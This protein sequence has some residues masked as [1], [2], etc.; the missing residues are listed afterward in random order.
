MDPSRR[1]LGDTAARVALLCALVL[2]FVL[3]F[4]LPPELVG[5]DHPLL[6]AVM[7]P[8]ALGVLAALLVR[9]IQRVMLHSDHGRPAF[10]IV[11]TLCLSLLVFA[12]TYVGLSQQS[13]EFNG[14]H[15]KVDAIYFTVVTMATVG[16]GD[17]TP[18][19]QTARVVVV[20]Q[21][22]YTLVFVTSGATAIGQQLRGRV[23]DRG[24]ARAA[25]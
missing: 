8:L 9:Q 24:R 18:T 11:L 15:T 23:A 17:I 12:T 3:Y 5:P 1:L 20:L 21:I 7:F 16:Y 22:V 14:L 2:L 4:V 6:R 25:G 10:G 19:G 13:G